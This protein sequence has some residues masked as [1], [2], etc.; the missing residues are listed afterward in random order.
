[1]SEEPV[2]LRDSLEAFFRHLGAPPVDSLRQVGERWPEVVGP[3]LAA[4]TRPAEGVDGVLLVLCD[5]PAWASQITW[6]ERQIC[7]RYRA[8]L[9]DVEI[10]RVRVRVVR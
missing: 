1:M 6:M 4:P 3:A 10:D 5:D 9:P 8:L 2:P 7:D